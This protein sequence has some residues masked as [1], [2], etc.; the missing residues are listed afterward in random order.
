M[1]LITSCIMSNSIYEMFC[2]YILLDS[3]FL[4][5]VVAL[6]GIVGL[7][8]ITEAQS[9]NL[10]IGTRFSTTLVTLSFFFMAGAFRIYLTNGIW[11]RYQIIITKLGLVMSSLAF[12]IWSIDII[13]ED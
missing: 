8:M 7:Q 1:Y 11:K 3:I 12:L 4:A 13:I 10:I 6:A 2:L 9:P 5:F